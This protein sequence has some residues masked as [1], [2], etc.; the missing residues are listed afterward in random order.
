MSQLKF[1]IVA[2]GNVSNKNEEKNERKKKI[3]SPVIITF[4]EKLLNLQYAWD[5]HVVEFSL[6]MVIF[7]LATGRHNYNNLFYVILSFHYARCRK[8][9]FYTVS[10]AFGIFS[11]LFCFYSFGIL[12]CD[13]KEQKVISISENCFNC[14]SGEQVMN[15]DK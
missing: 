3:E 10:F 12:L 4:F 13:N 11:F 9:L 2:S 15:V 6:K 14:L 5:R 7:L 8:N 1:K